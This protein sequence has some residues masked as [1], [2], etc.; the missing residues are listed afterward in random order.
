MATA[1]VARGE[2]LSSVRRQRGGPFFSFFSPSSLAPALAPVVRTR[3]NDQREH[4]REHAHGQVNRRVDGVRA[5]L[6]VLDPGRAN[7][8]T[9]P[10]VMLVVYAPSR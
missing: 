8:I 6:T 5:V 10:S 4:Q 1:N 7:R 2:P 3:P 9:R